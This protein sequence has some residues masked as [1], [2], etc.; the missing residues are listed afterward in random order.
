[1]KTEI[2]FK[3]C[4]KNDPSQV[5]KIFFYVNEDKYWTL[6]GDY[7]RE[8][9]PAVVWHNGYKGWYLNGKFHREDGPAIE[10]TDGRKSWYR[11]K[12]ILIK[13]T[14]GKQ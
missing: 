10:Y 13:K 3:R 4:I 2:Y 8:D 1:M 5:E 11:R 14:I 6:N 7:H 12:I 9:G